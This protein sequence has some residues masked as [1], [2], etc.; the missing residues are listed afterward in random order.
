MPKRPRA[1][2]HFFTVA[3]VDVDRAGRASPFNL[4]DM[5]RHDGATPVGHTA[6]VYAFRING[7]MPTRPRWQSFGMPVIEMQ[8]V[9]DG[10]TPTAIM[11]R[12]EAALEG[13]PDE[14]YLSPRAP[15]SR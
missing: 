8:P 14:S 15:R 6:K 5:L 2:D 9:D 10:E 11:H 7:G 13:N 1:N 3:R 12:S 4:L